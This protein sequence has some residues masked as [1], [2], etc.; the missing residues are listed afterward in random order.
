MKHTFSVVE[1]GQAA[2]F[3]LLD[4]KGF[5]DWW[6]EVDKEGQD[7]ILIEMAESV[8]RHLHAKGYLMARFKDEVKGAPWPIGTP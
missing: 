4:R 6:D 5:A 1:I 3:P 2:M 8:V 7:D